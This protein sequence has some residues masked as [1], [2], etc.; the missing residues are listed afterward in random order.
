[1]PPPSSGGIALVEMLNVLEGYDLAASGFGSATTVHRM[2][3]AM[4]RAYA[5]RARFVGDPDFNP[6]LPLA[7][8]LSKD[9]AARAA[10]DDSRRARLGLVARAFRVAGRE[11]GHD[12]SLGRGQG[13]QRRRADLHAGRRLRLEDRRAGRRLPAQ[14]RDGRFQRGPRA[15][16]CDRPDR[17]AAQPRRARQADALEH[18]A[19]DRDER[20]TPVHDARRRRRAAHHQYRPRGDRERGRLRDERAGGGG[21]AALSSPVAAGPD[22]R[23]DER[24]VAGHARAAGQP[25][26]HAEAG[27][28]L[29]EP[30][31][32]DRRLRRI[33]SRAPTTA[34]T[35]TAPPAGTRITT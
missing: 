17:H 6:E 16:G 3:E 33:C 18:D 7:R 19:H 27:L 26:P 9:Y 13:P 31:P 8:L 29:P 30:L 4:R 1:M 10:P 34:A 20:R 35:R 12:A 5:D 15:H 11:R 21:R 24:P 22:P 28:G 2:A 23:G 14:Q 32:G 25:R